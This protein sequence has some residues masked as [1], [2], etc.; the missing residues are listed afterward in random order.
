[1]QNA[2]QADAPA[3]FEA[4]YEQHKTWAIRFAWL[5]VREAAAAED[6]SHDAFTR[7][8]ERF[9]TLTN[10]SAYLRSTLTN[11]VY[12][13]S[14]RTGREERRLRLVSAGES[15]QVEHA[16]GG[17]MD[18][19]SRLPIRQRTAV[20][21]RYWVDLPVDD[22]A[23]AMSARPGTVKSWLSRA[24]AQLRKEIEP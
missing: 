21:L 13:R 24:N 11:A 14:R 4:F 17:M 20:V 10:P 23:E 2:T 19:I 5:M 7:V 6:I 18:A 8:F 1:M 15:T 12:E 16:S 3:T 9:D 22:I